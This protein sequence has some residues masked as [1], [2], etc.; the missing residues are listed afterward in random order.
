MMRD[1]AIVLGGGIGGIAAA[2]LLTRQ[3]FAVEI[4]EAGR[5]LAAAWRSVSTDR[6]PADLGVR[7]PRESG[8]AHADELL[9]HSDDTF[10]WNRLG[11][12]PREGHIV[13][14]HLNTDTPCPDARRLPPD[15]LAQARAELTARATTPDPREG[16]ANLEARLLAQFGPTLMEHLLRPACHALLGS[17]P[18]HLAWNAAQNRLPARIV[19]A[20]ADD[21]RTLQQLGA[22]RDRLAH[23]RTTDAP[24][25]RSAASYLYPRHG[26]IGRWIEGLEAALRR[27]GVVQHL[28]SQVAGLQRCGSRVVAVQLA[29]GSSLGCDLLVVATTPAALPGVSTVPTRSMPVQAGLLTVEGGTAPE[30]HWLTCYD[31]GAPFLRLAF[32]A[33][34]AGREQR[35]AP[36]WQIIVEAPAESDMPAPVLAAALERHGLLPHGARLRHH[37]VVATGRFAVETTAAAAAR[38]VALAGLRAL[39]NVAMLRSATGGHALVGDVIADAAR[40]ALRVAGSKVAA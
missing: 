19:I 2:L 4:I 26:G 36:A 17:D 3:G 13:H 30:L 25:S 38:E 27:Q 1:R 18:R 14:D 7:V 21:T 32:P 28:H 12:S 22:L 6:G 8:D 34:L 5:Q 39:D 37:A 9:F 23:P 11:P 31:P 20:D 29:N 33:N 10:S 40:M 15:M 16:A 35:R 24:A